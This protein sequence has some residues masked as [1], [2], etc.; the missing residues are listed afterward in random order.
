MTVTRASIQAVHTEFSDSRYDDALDEAI[1]EAYAIHADSDVTDTTL[2]LMVKWYAMHL[3]ATNPY[4]QDKVR[5]Q[6]E[7]GAYLENYELVAR[8][9]GGSDRGFS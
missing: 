1:T 8:P 9:A 2:D 7:V 3:V 5:R 4:A 6:G